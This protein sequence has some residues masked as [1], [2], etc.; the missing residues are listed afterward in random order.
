MSAILQANIQL[1]V[2]VFVIT[3]MLSMGLNLRFEHESCPI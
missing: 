3:G 1:L 2:M